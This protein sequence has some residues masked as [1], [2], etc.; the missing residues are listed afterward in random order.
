MI[1]IRKTYFHN[2]T[3]YEDVGNDFGNLKNYVSHKNQLSQHIFNM[4]LL[5]YGVKCNIIPIMVKKRLR[6]K[7][8]HE[9]LFGMLLKNKKKMRKLKWCSSKILRVYKFLKH[10]KGRGTKTFIPTLKTFF[11]F[12]NNTV[13]WPKMF[14]NLKIYQ[15]RTDFWLRSGFFW[16]KSGFFWFW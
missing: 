1:K 12:D 7:L 5:T 13:L 10:W 4:F 16:P 14:L 2:K 9:K 15:K 6:L 8:T 3:T 11:I